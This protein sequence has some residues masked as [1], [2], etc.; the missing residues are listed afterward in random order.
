MCV[1]MYIHKV[2]VCTCMYIFIC[3]YSY[4]RIHMY[5]FICTH[6]YVHIHCTYTYVYVYLCAQTHIYTYVLMCIHVHAKTPNGWFNEMC[7]DNL[8]RKPGK[9][10]C[11]SHLGE[12]WPRFTWATEAFRQQRGRTTG[13]K[14]SGTHQ[15]TTN[16]VNIHVRSRLACKSQHGKLE[17][18]RRHNHQYHFAGL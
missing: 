7:I 14:M 18:T 10:P 5:V 13:R 3:T 17:H 15:G 4:V 2:Y 11:A 8:N 16:F 6:S 9:H 12:F 1:N